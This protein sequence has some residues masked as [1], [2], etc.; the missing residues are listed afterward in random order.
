VAQQA[1]SKLEMMVLTTGAIH[2]VNKPLNKV[3]N[4]NLM[5]LK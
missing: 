2:R 1:A 4:Q 3:N 5:R